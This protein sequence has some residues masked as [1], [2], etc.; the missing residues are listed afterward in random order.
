M[1]KYLVTVIKP[2]GYI[3]SECFREIAETLQFGL[4][5][6]GHEARILD[7]LVDPSATNIILGA[8][9]L[10]SHEEKLLPA[11]SIIYNLEQLGAASLSAGYY[12]LAHRFQIWDYSRLNIARW[13][14]SGCLFPPRLVEVGYA[15]ELRRIASRPEQNIDV[16]FYG[17]MNEHRLNVLRRLRDAGVKVHAVFGI[18]GRERDE[19]IAR[20]KIVLN[21]HCLETQL[22]EV[23]R[24]S[25]LLTNSKAVVSEPSPDMGDYCNAVA[26]FASEEIVEG[27]LGLLRNDERRR[28]LELRG[29]GYFSGQG[30][31]KVLAQVIPV[32][33]REGIDQAKELRR[34]YLDMVQRCV[35]NLIYE[36]P[37]QDHWSPHKF[38]SELRE[39]GRDWPLQAHSMI[40]NRRMSN[41]RQIAEFVIEKGIPGDL[42]ETGVWRGGACIMM[43]AVLQAYGVDDRRVWAADSFC[44]LPEPNPEISADAGDKHHT[45][46]ELAVSLEKVKANFCKY[47]LLDGQVQFLQ[48]WFSET[49]PHAPIEKLAVLRLDGDMYE[50]TMDVLQNLYDKVSEGGF[51]IVDD[52]GAVQGCQTAVLEFRSSRQITDPIHPIDG[53]GVFWRK[54]TSLQTMQT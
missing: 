20:S 9:L 2:A 47:G 14:E 42:M 36:D 40:G 7:N 53:C 28:Q 13:N 24:V 8:H 41:L 19:L 37:N 43:R 44:G 51:I 50:S 39:L 16:L 29:F 27:C 23:V 25:Y 21:L 49:L 30:V 17:S 3:H 5:S 4:R 22:F 46:A 11:G 10:E 48:G 52:F 31:A 35:I 45:F 26:V 15:P 34:L 38:S 6:L 32:E 54:S 12:A 1:E 33:R 18:Y